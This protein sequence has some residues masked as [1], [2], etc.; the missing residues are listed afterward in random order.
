[1][2]Q[3]F[4]NIARSLCVY[5]FNFANGLIQ[6]MKLKIII[7]LLLF[8]GS[9]LFIAGSYRLYSLY[10]LSDKMEHTVG[11]VREMKTE[12]IYRYRKMKYEHIAHIEYKVK[13]YSRHVRM[14]VYNPFIFRGSEIALWYNPDRAGEVVLPYQEGWN[15]GACGAFGLFCL[16]LGLGIIKKNKIWN[17][18]KKS[19]E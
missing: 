18:R 17:L 15:W 4:L 10:R 1:M 19:G 2:S 8:I 7:F 6:R 14:K 3:K 16:F 5:E 12:K 13:D 11:I 9:I